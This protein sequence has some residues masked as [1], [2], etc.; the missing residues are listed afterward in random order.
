VTDDELE[1][2]RI[3]FLTSEHFERESVSG[4]AAKLGSFLV[5]AEPRDGA[6]YLEAVR[7]A[8]PASCSASR[9]RGAARGATVGVLLRTASALRSTPRRPQRCGSRRRAR[10]ARRSASVIRSREPSS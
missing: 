8:T 3:N 1:K 7:T 6:R 10:R 5:S 2:A 9:A 4:L